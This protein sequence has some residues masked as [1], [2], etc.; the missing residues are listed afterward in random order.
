[1]KFFLFPLIILNM[2]QLNCETANKKGGPKI[3]TGNVIFIH[4]DGSA[5]SMWAAL[6]LLEVGPDG[7]LNWDRMEQMG[8]YRGHLTNSLN[9]SSNG[10]ATVHAFG[11]KVPY[12][13]YGS[14]PDQPIT[15]LSGKTYSI[16]VEAG[17]AGFS[18]ALINS[19]QICEP[20]TGAF[21]ANSASRKLTDEISLQ[22]I[23]SGV[24]LILSGGEKILLPKE[25]IGYH[26]VAGVR[27]DGRNLIEYARNLGYHVVYTREQMNG[28]PP[29]TDRI[30]GVFS[31]NH[32]FNDKTEENLQK[33]NLP[34]YVPSAPTVAEMTAFALSFFEKKKK[35][36]FI[37]VEEEGTDN[38]ANKNNARGTLEALRRA[39]QAIGVVI[40]YINRHPKTMLITA[41]DSDAGSMKII[42]V[43]NPENFNRPL[44]VTTDNGAPIDGTKG[45]N[46]LP[47]VAKPDRYGTEL[48]F[49]LGWVSRDDLAGGVVAKAHGLNSALLPNNTDNTDIYRMMYATLFGRWLK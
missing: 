30:L 37:V 15:S 8:L 10:A 12:H 31:A 36:F 35:P 45:T 9:S 33:N 24:E 20:G 2:L 1:M 28:L 44:P 11:K 40:N 32:T 5:A 26:G 46:S 29:G 4:P 14:H 27:Q 42:G 34:H 19:G 21:V 49:G 23:E 38:F 6:R 43:R 16:M 13:Y 3:P 25:V 17:K 22:I 48:R 7:L 39:D 41:A 18:R 47:F